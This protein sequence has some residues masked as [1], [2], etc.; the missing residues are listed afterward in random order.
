MH[1]DITKILRGER[2][3]VGSLSTILRCVKRE[4]TRILQSSKDPFRS[5]HLNLLAPELF[6]KF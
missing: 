4:S 1:D 2:L 5:Y 3:L 6:F